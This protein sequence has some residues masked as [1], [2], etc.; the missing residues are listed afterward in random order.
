VRASALKLGDP[1]DEASDIGTV[2]NEKQFALIGLNL[3][4]PA[5][6]QQDTMSFFVTSVGKGN[7]ADLRAAHAIE[8]GWVQVNQG[9]GQT[10]GHSYGGSMIARGR[11]DDSIG[12]PSLGLQ[13]I[14][15]IE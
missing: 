10:P 3:T 14:H 7:G 9:L 2:I 1:L 11:I 15:I 4:T 12:S 5:Q 6:A 13:Q 8:A